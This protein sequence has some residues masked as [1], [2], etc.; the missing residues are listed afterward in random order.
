VQP[1]DE[2]SL[3]QASIIFGPLAKVLYEI[4]GRY[5]SE[6]TAPEINR[7]LEIISRHP[8]TDKEIQLVFSNLIPSHLRTMLIDLEVNKE[9]QQVERNGKLYCVASDSYFPGYNALPDEVD[10]INS[11]DK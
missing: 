8:M 2:G 5:G 1:P 10:L 11:K 9:I 7:I 6:G 4:Q 3:S